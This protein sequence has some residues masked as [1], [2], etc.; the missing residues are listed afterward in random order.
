MT[1]EIRTVYSEEE[2]LVMLHTDID[3]AIDIVSI[4]SNSML[5]ELERGVTDLMNLTVE[6]KN[7]YIVCKC[8]EHLYNNYYSD[9]SILKMVAEK[10]EH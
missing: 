2:M 3:K 7:M 5:D 1:D 4:A 6:E 8:F 10:E 9:E